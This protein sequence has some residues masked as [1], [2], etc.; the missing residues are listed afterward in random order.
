MEVWFPASIHFRSQG[1]H[2]TSPGAVHGFRL[3]PGGPWER[4]G[5]HRLVAPPAVPQLA[6]HVAPSE[7]AAE[8]GTGTRPA[9]GGGAAEQRRHPAGRKRNVCGGVAGLG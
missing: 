5:V 1:A 6:A 8:A 7:A 2:E 4:Q 3:G 9:L